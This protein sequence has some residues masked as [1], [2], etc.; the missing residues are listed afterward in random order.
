MRKRK[1]ELTEHI[2]DL[3]GL[4]LCGKAGYENAENCF[5][6]MIESHNCICGKIEEILNELE[7][8]ENLSQQ[9]KEKL[10]NTTVKVMA[11]KYRA[12]VNYLADEVR[13]TVLGEIRE[14][15]STFLCRFIL[16]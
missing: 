14:K 7:K 4:Y 2:Q 12:A 10:K 5:S 3:I 9:K 15:K 11:L 13:K 1:R 8:P 16:D 6:D